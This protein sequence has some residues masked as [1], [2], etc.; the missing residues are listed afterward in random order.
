MKKILVPT[1]FSSPAKWATEVAISIAKKSKALIVLL[2]VVEQPTSESFNAEG[3]MSLG[4][5]WED[6]LFTL[7][8]IGKCRT[9]LAE[10][11]KLIE[12]AGVSVNS[13]LKLGNPFHGIKTVVSE[14]E[15]DLV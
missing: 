11:A 3:E 4:N 12:D 15:C 6:R 2:H 14:Q 8:L 13:E 5:G 1:D 7:K 9:Q 10:A